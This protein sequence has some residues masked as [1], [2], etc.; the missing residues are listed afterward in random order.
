MDAK[1]TSGRSRTT[2]SKLR[3]SRLNV[4]TGPTQRSDAILGA[5]VMM[6]AQTPRKGINC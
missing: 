3:R 1:P 6:A 5:L 2:R 4:R